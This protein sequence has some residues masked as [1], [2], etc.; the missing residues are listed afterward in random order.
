MSRE[1]KASCIN[2]NVRFTTLPNFK[3]KSGSSVLEKRKSSIHTKY[4]SV[5][6]SEIIHFDG[7]TERASAGA[8]HCGGS[9]TTL[10]RSCCVRCWCHCL[11]RSQLIVGGA[12]LPTG[13]GENRSQ[14]VAGCAYHMIR[15]AISGLH[16]KVPSNTPSWPVT[17][18]LGLR[19]EIASQLE[20][21]Q[22]KA[23][24]FGH[25]PKKLPRREKTQCFSPVSFKRCISPKCAKFR[26]CPPS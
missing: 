18:I 1:S 21:P 9:A 2:P 13:K 22:L 3:I 24:T 6:L 12:P 25:V 4:S 5:S 10:Q 26:I 14:L 15:L 11:R 23:L 17:G 19:S 20:W 16:V 8:R 7:I